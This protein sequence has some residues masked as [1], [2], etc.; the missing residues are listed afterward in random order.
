MLT[1]IFENQTWNVELK[2]ALVEKSNIDNK[3]W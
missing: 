1:K 2:Y 3:T